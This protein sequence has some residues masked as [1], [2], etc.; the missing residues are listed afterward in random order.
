M[1]SIRARLRRWWRWVLAR[2]RLDLAA[3]C[4]MSLGRGL[5]DDFHDYPDDEAGQPWHMVEL[6]CKRCGKTFYI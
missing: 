6:K 3:V 5:F 1:N 2:Y 4:E